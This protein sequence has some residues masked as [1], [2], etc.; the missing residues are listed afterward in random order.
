M[1]FRKLIAIIIILGLIFGVG[2]FFVSKNKPTPK[3]ENTPLTADKNFEKVNADLNGDGV[4]ETL[5]LSYVNTEED[6]SVTSLVALDKDG[7]EI[8]SLPK[9]MPIPV[10]FSN[11]G[12]VYSPFATS[13]RQ[14]VSFDFIV[15]PHSSE[16]M[17]FALQDEA[18][19]V[20]PV[21]LTNDV[22]GP[23]S[24]LFWSGEVGELVVKDLDNDGKLEVVETVDEYPKDGT[25]TKEEEDAVNK[26]FKDSDKE[27]YDGMMRI[28][29]REKGDRGN[30]VVWGIYQFNG[31][32]FEEQTGKN[33]DKY[34]D[35]VSK[36]LKAT[37]P[38][39]PI[40]MKRS[41]MSKDSLDYNLFMRNFWTHRLNK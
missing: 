37:Y 18:K 24:C 17:F 12:K 36:Y 38:T 19:E 29:K 26:V 6:L 22:K 16:T 5:R 32:F 11:S 10:P 15:G 1:K 34:Y 39:Y 27:T 8:G 31:S 30:K 2:Y 28:P 21:C 7:K 9:S 33:Y 25:L 40:I 13:K 23:E 41:T 20:L 4:L 3:T 14:F 35:L